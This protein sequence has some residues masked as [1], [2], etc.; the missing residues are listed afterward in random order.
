MTPA[1]HAWTVSLSDV[2]PVIAETNSPTC[3]M[4]SGCS[5]ELFEEGQGI[6]SR[7]A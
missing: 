4:R 5:N 1:N 6:S 7:Q 2:R 3:A